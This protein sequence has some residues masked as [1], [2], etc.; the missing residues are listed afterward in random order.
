MAFF[1]AL[2]VM[3]AFTVH[4]HTWIVGASGMVAYAIIIVLAFRR[5]RSVYLSI[6]GSCSLEEAQDFN[7]KAKG[8]MGINLFMMLAFLVIS[9]A[10]R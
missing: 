10:V 3:T 8:F 9:V 5:M 1:V 2:C 7:S 4:T 6:R